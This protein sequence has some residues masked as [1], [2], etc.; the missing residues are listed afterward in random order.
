MKCTTS[1]AIV[2]ITALGLLSVAGDKAELSGSPS[3]LTLP[4]EP[5]AVT[6]QKLESALTVKDF[7][8]AKVVN[9]E[10][11]RLGKVVDFIL[12]SDDGKFANVVIARGGLL[13]IRRTYVAVPYNKIEH[14][15][16]TK[17]LVWNIAKA[18]FLTVAHKG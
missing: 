3:R 12:E 9:T 7:L 2:G 4:K 10:G 11:E 8:G 5:V 6:R 14:L 13:G 1:V 18:D 17:N 15:P 16:G